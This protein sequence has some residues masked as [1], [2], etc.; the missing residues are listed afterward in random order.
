MGVADNRSYKDEYLFHDDRTYNIKEQQPSIHEEPAINTTIKENPYRSNVEIEGDE[1]VLQPDLSALFKAKGPKHSKGGMDVLLKPESFIF[2]DFKGLSFGEKDYELFELKEASKTKDPTKN[3]PAEVL[4]KNIDVKHYNTLV[5]ILDDPYKDDIAKKSAALMLEKY[6]QSL[7][8]IA[9]VQESKKGFPQGVPA[10]A[11]GTAPVYDASVKDAI[12]ENKQYM[13]AGGTTKNPYMQRGGAPWNLQNL[14]M[15]Q[16]PQPVVMPP[17]GPAYIPQPANVNPNQVTPPP[18]NQ[19]TAKI[20]AAQQQAKN[21]IPWGLWQGDQMPVFQDRYGIS[22]AADKFPTL[23]NW[24]AVATQ[25]G[26]TGPKDNLSFQKWLYSSSPENK[27]VIDKWHQK[28]NQGPN[29]GMFDQKVGIRW[30]N[31]INE[32]LTKKPVTP[33]YNPPPRTPEEE[34]K[35]VPGPQVPDLEITPQGS[36]Q[37]DW[38]FTPWQKLSQLNQLGQYAL[39]K[40]YMPYRSRYNA[41]YVD[42]ALVNPEQ[43]VGDIKGVANQQLS[44]IGT[45]N[46]ILRNAQAASVAGQVMNQV[47][48][49]R[50]QYDNQNA[51]ILNQTRQYNNQVKNNESL[52]NMGNDQQYYQQ[53][54]EGRKNFDNMRSYTWNNYMNNL[55]GDVQTNQKLAYNLLTLD[56]PAYGFDWR[57]GNLTRNKK[58][59]L[60]AQSNGVNDRYNDLVNMVNSISDPLEK[61]KLMVKLEGLRTFGSAQQAP[62]NPFAQKKG[63]RVKNPYKY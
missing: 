55:L 26:Y 50:S 38:R 58:N 3:T 7:G 1:I 33:G 37:A 23:K 21:P 18:Q 17:L 25:L 40:R 52:V 31:A 47:P 51:Q 48:G 30:A 27:A 60:D 13:R 29:A 53:A 39:T 32:I 5:N 6:L 54:V 57:T 10:F 19:Q 42:P 61:A 63:G 2:S 20:N 11:M 35:I 24:D 4:K 22:N 28:Y 46:P 45:L 49:V 36:K 12:E 8:N 62:P 16:Q 56:N 34:K 41:T 14:P 9:F 15:P 59:I 43:A 44:S